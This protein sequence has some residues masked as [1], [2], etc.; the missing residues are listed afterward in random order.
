MRH[1]G[2]GPK[3]GA[4]AA[5]NRGYRWGKAPPILPTS[6][7]L[8]LGGRDQRYSSLV[9]NEKRIMSCVIRMNPA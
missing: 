6:L 4:R 8:D 1:S 7:F 3:A 5:K 9:Q 2:A